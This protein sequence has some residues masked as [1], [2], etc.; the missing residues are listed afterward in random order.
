MM[1]ILNHIQLRF[2][3]FFLLHHADVFRFSSG[4]GKTLTAA[5]SLNANS[6]N[7]MFV[8]R[9]I[10]NSNTGYYLCVIFD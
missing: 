7:I 10:I 5:A 4:Q 9:L 6:T 8:F 1:R 3:L 2:V